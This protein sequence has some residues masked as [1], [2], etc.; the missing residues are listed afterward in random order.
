MGRWVSIVLVLAVVGALAW[1]GNSRLQ[2]LAKK[3]ARRGDGGAV[4][5]EVATIERGPIEHRRTFTG[6]LA[7]LEYF[8]HTSPGQYRN[9][10]DLRS[11]A[12]N[13]GGSRR[14]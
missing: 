8:D 5:V 10:A 4:P 6:T 2:D 12:G 1:V 9:H 11:S 3:P 14:A 7:R 13:V